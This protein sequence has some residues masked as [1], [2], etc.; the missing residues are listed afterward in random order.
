LT[1]RPNHCKATDTLDP[2]WRP[3]NRTDAPDLEVSYGLK[4][5]TAS[6][7]QKQPR[8]QPTTDCEFN[9]QS[10][11][12]RIKQS[13]QAFGNNNKLALERESKEAHE[14]AVFSLGLFSN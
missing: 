1:F 11:T 4:N 3:E 6:D 10:A 7:F 13:E 12:Y 14:K 9:R 2:P 5:G 8:R